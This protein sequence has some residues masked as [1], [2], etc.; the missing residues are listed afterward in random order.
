M[1]R[2]FE[3]ASHNQPS[4][5]LGQRQRWAAARWCFL[6]NPENLTDKQSVKLTDVLR[7][8][9]R[10]VRAYLL[11]QDTRTTIDCAFTA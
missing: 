11:N 2:S 7:H 4:R 1:L 6:K 9:L 8:D 10:S 5:H 3:E